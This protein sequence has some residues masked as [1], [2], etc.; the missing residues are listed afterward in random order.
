MRYL[1]G[2]KIFRMLLNELNHAVARRFELLS[3]F[4]QCGEASTG[5]ATFR[6]LHFAAAVGNDLQK[7]LFT[8]R[9]VS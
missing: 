6:S 1:A 5:T 9:S 2:T 4:S 7:D 3:S 8:V